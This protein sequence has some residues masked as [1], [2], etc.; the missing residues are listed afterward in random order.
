[1]NSNLLGEGHA[2]YAYELQPGASDREPASWLLGEVARQ[3]TVILVR[4]DGRR[5][6]LSA[7]PELQARLEGRGSP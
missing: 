4:A 3:A 1:M 6:V 2:V 7:D 5:E